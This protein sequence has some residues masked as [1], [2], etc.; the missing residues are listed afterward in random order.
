MKHTRSGEGATGRS[1]LGLVGASPAPCCKKWDELPAARRQK[2]PWQVLHTYAHSRVPFTVGRLAEVGLIT[3]EQ[4]A[5]A[6]QIAVERD[7]VHLAG[8]KLYVGRLAAR[9]GRP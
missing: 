5:K 1:P 9:R 8:P 3:E 7:W 6:V 2:W 4:A